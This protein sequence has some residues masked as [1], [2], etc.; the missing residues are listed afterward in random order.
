MADSRHRMV[1][2]RDPHI[3]YGT[4]PSSSLKPVDDRRVNAH[5]CA[6]QCNS[7]MDDPAPHVDPRWFDQVA[8]HYFI[9]Q[10]GPDAWVH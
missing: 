8:D 7:V 9:G 4:R 6:D 3:H 1:I 10:R 5:G 2:N